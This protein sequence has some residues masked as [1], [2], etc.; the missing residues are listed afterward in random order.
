MPLCRGCRACL[1]WLADPDLLQLDKAPQ[2][3]AIIGGGLL[4]HGD[5]SVF[6]AASGRRDLV[7]RNIEA[8]AGELPGRSGFPEPE[9]A[10]EEANRIM[11][12]L[13]TGAA[14]YLGRYVLDRLIRDG[15]DLV[16]W[17]H[18][19]AEEPA[20]RCAVRAVELTESA[21]LRQWFAQDQPELLLHAAAMARVDECLRHPE[22]ARRV[23]AKATAELVGLCR[24]VAIPII[25]VSTDLVFDGEQAPYDELDAPNPVSLY[26]RT[27]A[28]GERAVL[29]YEQGTVVRIS[30]LYGPSR[31]GRA[32]FF[33]RQVQ[34]LLSG[35]PIELF[36]DEWR[37]PLDLLTAA[38]ALSLLAASPVPGILHLAGPERMS[39]F[40]MGQRLAEHLHV[41]PA[42]CQPS[43]REWLSGAEPR[44]RDTSLACNRWHSLFPQF[45]FP[46]FE[47]ALERMGVGPGSSAGS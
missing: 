20:G 2:R 16:A 1:L 23:N 14:G 6:S 15:H 19:S 39:R 24:E 17:V 10:A 45:T 42:L 32:S 7:G 31:G 25:Y 47:Q 37:T 46:S 13:L 3:A 41:D 26:G 18:R 27:K 30:L 22:Q 33:D 43:R 9:L 21:A 8:A 4:W 12:V 29:A 35:E 5:V 40:Q 11:R 28:A 34:A 36:V 38:A 44:P